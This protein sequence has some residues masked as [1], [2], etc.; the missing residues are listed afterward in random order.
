MSK[1]NKILLIVIIFIFILINTLF[2]L[3]KK[4]KNYKNSTADWLYKYERCEKKLP[5]VIDAKNNTSATYVSCVKEKYG[6]WIQIINMWDSIRIS[7]STSSWIITKNNVIVDRIDNNFKPQ[8]LFGDNYVFGQETQKNSMSKYA[9]YKLEDEEFIKIGNI[10]E[11]Y[12]KLTPKI[13]TVGYE[14]I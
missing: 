3:P 9:V 14:I 11:E 2:V 5:S 6:G 1:R 10:D 7:K 8:I 12:T 13:R 4:P